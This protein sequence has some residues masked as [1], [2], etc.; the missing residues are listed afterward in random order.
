MAGNNEKHEKWEIHSVKPGLWQENWKKWKWE[1][2]TEG[3]AICE[4]NWKSWKI[5]N[6]HYMSWN[7][8]ETLKNVENEKCT[9]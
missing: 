3:L 8:R 6:T 4:G 5:R 2:H 7:I 1:M 9:L